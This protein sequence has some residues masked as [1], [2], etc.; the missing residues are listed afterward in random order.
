MLYNLT[1]GYLQNS[2]IRQTIPR[3]EEMFELASEH[4][5]AKIQITR[6]H[7]NLDD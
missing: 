4:E 6:C 3:I 2:D 1:L 5:L 7:A